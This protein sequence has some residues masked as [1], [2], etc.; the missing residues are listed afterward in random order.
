[1]LQSWL[2]WRILIVDDD[3]LTFGAKGIGLYLSTY[4]ND[5][6]ALAFPSVKRIS[7]EMNISNRVAI[8]YVK[9]LATKGWLE[10]Q[11][12]FGKTTVYHA[13]VPPTIRPSAEIAPQP[14]D[15]SQLSPSNDETSQVTKG[16]QSNDES[17]PAVVTNRHKNNQENNQSNN[18]GA[19]S[20]SL[21]VDKSDAPQ[22]ESAPPPPEPRPVHVSDPQTLV[23]ACRTP[24]QLS[25]TCRRLGFGDPPSGMYFAQAKQ[26]AMRKAEQPKAEA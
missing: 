1:M 24:D 23:R 15:K 11:K 21:P 19:E 10:K 12:R 20:D 22:Q 5:R 6:H 8:K 7:D 9:E 16:H 2:N 25:Q 26:W 3:D 4:M 13:K 14:V 17:S 18:Q